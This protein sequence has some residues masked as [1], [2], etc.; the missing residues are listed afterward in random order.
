MKIFL[1]GYHNPNFLTI[2]EYL[3]RAIVRLGHELV[4]MDDRGHVIP[5]RLRK[6]FGFLYEFDLWN[7]NRHILSRI[8]QTMP[9][10]AIITGG[11][12]ITASTIEKINQAG[13]ESVLWTIDA[14][15]EFDLIIKP[16]SFYKYIFCQGTEAV[17]ILKEN[18]IP[19]PQW[20]PMA[21]DPDI[22]KSV[23]LSEEEKK[24]FGSDIVFVGSYY[25][26]RADL[27]RNVVNFDLGIW[28]PGWERLEKDD[29]LR[30]C[31]K[32]GS[33]VPEEFNKIYSAAKIVIVCHYQDG[34]TPCYQASPKVFEAMAC[35]AFVL[36]DDQKD[37]FSLFE[38]GKHLV[39]YKNAENLTRKI[40]YFLSH[41]IERKKIS[42]QGYEETIKH[43][44]YVNRV[45]S[46]F[47][48]ISGKT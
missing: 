29:P 4:I 26:N 7:I 35:D 38:D 33:V 8:K 47:S 39:K 1:S 36:V 46:L 6:R 2:T 45:R 22:H 37:V 17:D 32:G 31:I 30:K 48:Y 5:G 28:G 44:T 42:L 21:C 34:K 43:H 11:H 18:G 20:M 15:R 3:E 41:P 16:A 27:L 24:K 10:V 19:V 9:K 25:K 13:I 14:P 40:E 23:Q 12:R